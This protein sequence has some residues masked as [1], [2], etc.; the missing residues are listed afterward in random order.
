[1]TQRAFLVGTIG[2]SFYFIS[3]TNALPPAF[4]VLTWLALS[5]LIASAA[6][7]LLSLQGLKCRFRVTRAGGAA[8]WPN[9]EIESDG[10][11]APQLE[12]RL[13]NGGTLNKTGLILMVK[14]RA[15]T[16]DGAAENR[17]ATPREYSRRF[18][19]EAL[20]ATKSLTAL[21]PL[22]E[23][24]RGVYRVEEIRITGSDVLGLFRVIGRYRAEKCGEGA[25]RITVS[26]AFLEARAASTRGETEGARRGERGT[27]DDLRGT[28][29]YVAGDD[30]RA[31]HW[32]TTARLGRLVVREFDAAA[33]RRSF[34]AWNGIAPGA[35]STRAELDARGAFNA[36][37]QSLRL[38]MS[39]CA[40]LGARGDECVLLRLDA[41]PQRVVSG[42]AAF[43]TRCGETLCAASPDRVA[44]L[45]S[46]ALLKTRGSITRGDE[47]FFATPRADASL[48]KLAASWNAQGVSV[49]VA[50]LESPAPRGAST[51]AAKNA[52]RKNAALRKS[53]APIPGDAPTSAASAFGA[54]VGAASHSAAVGAAG[55]ASDS[56]AASDSAVIFNSGAA[57]HFSVSP[58]SGD[59]N[60]AAPSAVSSAENLSDHSAQ[61]DKK[62]RDAAPDFP[63]NGAATAFARTRE[64]SAKNPRSEKTPVSRDNFYDEGA[65]LFG[66]TTRE[67][68]AQL[69]A[70]GARVVVVES[71]GEART[72][73]ENA[74]G[75]MLSANANVGATRRTSRSA[76]PIGA[77]FSE[78]PPR[79]AVS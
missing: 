4:S 24:P 62:L 61:P 36:T 50:L 79:E 74:M 7:A 72:A 43:L 10:E 23:L 8:T 66:E 5:L 40:A 16:T 48:A 39:L 52:Q 56:D 32:K 19:I 64:R 29:P 53:D 37:E 6:V 77:A 21:L 69:R 2:L 63:S 49:T 26:P 57:S 28:R 9:D 76:E 51:R 30:L 13:D 58:T 65:P 20:T 33:R 42:R 11:R 34:V 35:A 78:A 25:L 15:E 44:P 1:M 27:N 22:D 14:L 55:I 71:G 3:V 45:S 47:L 68:A 70:A 41:H 12:V 59:A 73:I 67:F 18:V 31:V 54:S 46:S 17:R 38:A 75:E 60:R